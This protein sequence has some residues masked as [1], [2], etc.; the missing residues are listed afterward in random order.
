[1]ISYF[2]LWR[3]LEKRGYQRKDIVRLAGISESTYRKLLASEAVRMDVLQRI[4]VALSVDVGGRCSLRAKRI[5][6]NKPFL[7]HPH[8]GLY[9]GR[10]AEG[11]VR[12]DKESH[13]RAKVCS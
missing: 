8:A 11:E 4:C 13:D 3:L 6:M 9:R 7:R 10:D 1:M 5:D 12:L 2:K